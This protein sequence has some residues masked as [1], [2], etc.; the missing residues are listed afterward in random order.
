MKRILLLVHFL[1]LGC[2][3]L[4]AQQVNLQ[5]NV[6]T[7]Q[8]YSSI[9]S[10]H[11][12]VITNTSSVL[13]DSI[14]YKVSLPIGIG[15]YIPVLSTNIKI[16]DSTKTNEFVFTVYNLNPAASATLLYKPLA[17]CQANNLLGS[18]FGQVT[19]LFV[20][21]AAPVMAS[22]QNSFN[23]TAKVNGEL[24]L[25]S[26][27]GSYEYLNHPPSSSWIASP[28][29][30]INSFI[31]DHF[32]RSY[33]LKS[34]D[35]RAVVTPGTEVGYSGNFF[36]SAKANSGHR[37]DSIAIYIGDLA[38]VSTRIGYTRY[39]SV[40]GDTLDFFITIPHG[41]IVEVRE[42][43]TVI[44]CLEYFNNNSSLPRGGN[45][46][47][48]M[49]WGF[50]TKDSCGSFS[51]TQV[52]QKD[53]TKKSII[54]ITNDPNGFQ[55][56]S[57]GTT[58]KKIYWIK[59][60]GNESTSK[61][62]YRLENSKNVFAYSKGSTLLL[63]DKYNVAHT[64]QYMEFGGYGWNKFTN[65]VTGLA[66]SVFSGDIK[67]I[68]YTLAPGDSVRI[69]Y[70]EVICCVPDT[71]DISKY[72]PYNDEFHFLENGVDFAFNTDCSVPHPQ[73]KGGPNRFSI[74]KQKLIIQPYP[75]TTGPGVSFNATYEGINSAL[76]SS[77]GLFS[78]TLYDT[79]HSY[80][81][82][83]L[84]LSDGLSLY[85]GLNALPSFTVESIY[86]NF[87]FQVFNVPNTGNDHY[88]RGDEETWIFRMKLTDVYH[89]YADM[90]RPSIYNIFEKALMDF[91]IYTHCTDLGKSDFKLTLSLVPGTTQQTCGCEIPFASKAGGVAVMCPGCITPGAYFIQ[92]PGTGKIVDIR[93]KN[94]GPRDDDDNGL[95]D[96][97]EGKSLIQD[98][99]KDLYFTLGDTIL[100]RLNIAISDGDD[101]K[102]KGFT[103]NTMLTQSILGHLDH[104]FLEYPGYPGDKINS[105]GAWFELNG[106]RKHV[107]DL[108]PGIGVRYHVTAQDFGLSGFAP[109][110]FSN[111]IFSDTARI[112][113]N[114]TPDVDSPEWNYYAY[115]SDADPANGTDI[116]TYLND[117]NNVSLLPIS[118]HMP[119]LPSGIQYFCEGSA[120]N[121]RYVPYYELY[122]EELLNYESGTRNPCV[123]SLYT[124]YRTTHNPEELAGNLSAI[125]YNYFP[126]EVRTYRM[127]DSLDQ[128][129]PGGYTIKN[130]SPFPN[131]VAL[132]AIHPYYNYLSEIGVYGKMIYR[133]YKGAAYSG[134]NTVIRR[135]SALAFMDYSSSDR[136]HKFKVPLLKLMNNYTDGIQ[137]TIGYKTPVYF[138]ESSSIMY[139][140]RMIP[141]CNEAVNTASGDTLYKTRFIFDQLSNGLNIVQKKHLVGN[142]TKPQVGLVLDYSNGNSFVIDKDTT[143]LNVD[144]K[145][146]Q[147]SNGE[148]VLAPNTFIKTSTMP[149]GV[150]IVGVK[151]NGTLILPD[152]NGFFRL[153]D[154]P[155]AAEEQIQ[156]AATYTCP[157]GCDP[158]LVTPCLQN[159]PV[160]LFFGW[161]CDGY[162]TNLNNTCGLD[163]TR[164]FITTV[165]A[166]LQVQENL[167]ALTGKSTL[168]VCDTL[169]Y[170]I[171]ISSLYQ[172]LIKNFDVTITKPTGLNYVGVKNGAVVADLVTSSTIHFK[173]LYPAGLNVFSPQDSIIL[174]FT[175]S[176]N[177]RADTL[178][179]KIN[180]T[181]YCGSKDSVSFT[182]NTPLFVTS[183][184]PVDSL[185]MNL[186][187]QSIQSGQ[188]TIRLNYKNLRSTSTA[189]NT[190]LIFEL[191]V[192]FS[193]V[194]NTSTYPMNMNGSLIEWTLPVLNAM[195][196]NYIDVVI[197]SSKALKCDTVVRMAAMLESWYSKSC[198]TENCN[199][200]VKTVKD[201]CFS[202]VFNNTVVTLSG[203]DTV[204]LGE[205]IVLTS[206]VTG[207][208]GVAMYT[209]YKIVGNV[210]QLLSGPS[211]S[212]TYTYNNFTANTIFEV[213][214]NKGG[215]PDTA[216]H[217][218]ILGSTAYCCTYKIGDF[219]AV[220]DLLNKPK[221][222][223]PITALRN[224]PNGIIGMDFCMGYNATIMRPTGV[225]TLGPVVNHGGYI[226]AAVANR[227][228]PGE[229]HVTIYYP[230]GPGIS[231]NKQ[232]AGTGDVICIEFEIL[233]AAA[234]NTA[235]PVIICQVDGKDELDEAY[236]LYEKTACW[237][238]G[239]VTLLYNSSTRA[240]LLNPLYTSGANP[241][242]NPIGGGNTGGY[243]VT[244]NIYSLDANCDINTNVTN[245][246]QS[247]INGYFTSPLSGSSQIKILRDVVQS[248]V[249]AKGTFMRFVNGFD[250]QYLYNLTILKTKTPP[251][252]VMVAGDVN[253]NGDLRG[254]DLTLL[255]Q[256]IVE[257]I[258]EFPQVWNNDLYTGVKLT[259]APSLDW[260]FIDKTTVDTAPRFKRSTNYP[261]RSDA[262][263]GY[264]RDKTPRIDPCLPVY[265]QCKNDVP[266]I[267]Y[268]VLLGDLDKATI[269]T[270]P[271]PTNNILPG[272][273]PYLKTG[274]TASE[275]IVDVEHAQYLGNNVYRIPVMHKYKFEYGKALVSIDMLIDYDQSKIQIKE[276][277]Y[278]YSTTDAAVSMMWNNSDDGY[279]MLTSFTT[280]D[281]IAHTA[282]SYYLDVEKYT[283]E[284]FNASNFG[285]L[286]FLLNGELVTA[287]I[288]LG[289]ILTNTD[290]PQSV[291]KPHITVIPNPAVGQSTIEF[292]VS[293][294]SNNNRLVITDVL[295]R[296]VR[297]YEGIAEYGMLDLSTAD[298]APG[299]YICTI[300]GENGFVLTEKFQV[301]K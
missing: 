59:N 5:Y 69:E 1:V 254:N 238:P 236:T 245:I 62:I 73:Q 149:T 94:M 140:F 133:N 78:N 157:G 278:A 256:R 290:D 84:E 201:S 252:Y 247:N 253:M 287:R 50:F 212:N 156:L 169:A 67:S 66:D 134:G 223:I 129:F 143:F 15:Y 131:A 120:V 48:Y 12:I 51:R 9:N 4:F 28:Y 29:W 273:N 282:V 144:L 151:R 53:P 193:Y 183:P 160:D 58:Q 25:L 197:Q 227:D 43:V 26:N 161:N 109:G 300:R 187:C 23:V 11:S 87:Q 116:I 266:P 175:T 102:A 152:A 283:N 80:I 117:A 77:T 64:F 206:S 276:V 141:D 22:I 235:Y 138:D 184:L 76:F 41:K 210:R 178:N 297:T 180:G 164:F 111:F 70:D 146:L 194:S 262:T 189:Y 173:D 295:G 296:I 113:S 292:A 8:Q 158:S 125:S 174:L 33:I 190:K 106:I 99:R 45:T 203:K 139:N 19:N 101:T 242:G 274:A 107:I 182:R 280:L 248:P 216:R 198:G 121:I 298:L 153:G 211:T 267:Y 6:S 122:W 240:R 39:K 71:F 264:W 132:R 191:P 21:P 233:S 10:D 97:L 176:C 16:T 220:C 258:T 159:S 172:G 207:G 108:D 40:A 195:Q 68:D 301:R 35:A 279:F 268:G 123:K 250:T 166:A 284:P 52:I 275:L 168:E 95:V 128:R 135:D 170:K 91:K 177:Y 285:D 255:Q 7:V 36:F 154:V 82:A 81:Y 115:F 209:W 55:G 24:L 260:R 92:V 167:Y 56:C 104:L 93:R 288:A 126:Y 163:T 257:Q 259:P 14:Q 54:Q 147:V 196:S 65:C 202:T 229:V 218:V 231:T 299:M 75:A 100:T 74:Y 277:S 185:S 3:V 217:T 96:A 79:S 20:V 224:V 294:N 38:N 150:N 263:S 265:P 251:W 37:V 281:S 34:Q 205:S 244:A 57:F 18:Q 237:K 2:S 31:G 239:S 200:I 222:C 215:C 179:V 188:T 112:V 208:S 234:M 103:Y 124:H 98:K 89:V 63:Y 60:I 142:F 219:T 214:A 61:I 291:N 27:T 272:Q 46:N 226:G 186:V 86:G 230:F 221:V 249:Q 44:G 90:T 114:L 270:A 241:L 181:T 148:W 47:I 105:L 213:E 204:C 171:K 145:N 293:N 17:G 110:T 130:K 155:V 13:I 261:F 162:P 289:N 165:R 136:N 225:V 192:P 246:T 30:A 118:Q 83:K 286:Q 228:N 199:L 42:Y 127:P 119:L 32:S 269:A 72:F 232:F 88:V 243:P 271:L 49:K 85:N 137:D